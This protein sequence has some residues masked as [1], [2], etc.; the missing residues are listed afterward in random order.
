MTSSHVTIRID[1]VI[2][3]TSIPNTKV[4]LRQKLMSSFFL[5]LDRLKRQ[6][7][8]CLCG[9]SHEGQAN[10]ASEDFVKE[11][12]VKVNYIHVRYILITKSVRMGLCW[13]ANFMSACFAMVSFVSFEIARQTKFCT[14]S[15]YIQ[16]ASR[17]CEFV[18][19]QGVSTW[20]PA[21]YCRSDKETLCP[22][23]LAV[24]WW[25]VLIYGRTPAV[26]EFLWER[27]FHCLSFQGVCSHALAA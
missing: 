24:F 12:A 19:V 9:L 1:D 10:W 13:N 7:V 14:A 21:L 18:H 8:V 11:S 16:M 27:D 22:S 3:L 5:Q 17:L 20:W 26:L 6:M 25:W 4:L 15:F 23:F 2:I